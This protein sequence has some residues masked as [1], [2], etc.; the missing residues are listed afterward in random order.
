MFKNTYRSLASFVD[1]IWKGI[2]CHPNVISAILY[3]PTKI[4]STFA[5]NSCYS[6]L[7]FFL[8]FSFNKFN[9]PQ[10]KNL[11]KQNKSRILFYT[12]C[13]KIKT[14]TR[15]CCCCCCC[16]RPAKRSRWSNQK[17]SFRVLF[18]LRFIWCAK[19][20]EQ[21]SCCC[22]FLSFR[23]ETKTENKWRT[24]VVNMYC[25]TMW[26][27]ARARARVR[28]HTHN[29]THTLDRGANIHFDSERV[30]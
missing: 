30:E 17:H 11:L 6:Y 2:K 28:S 16:F 25:N 29:R 21:I 8:F 1:C 14:S 20:K 12:C 13:H 24:F 4:A 22:C 3:N 26:A 23:L 27:W 7:C 9:F 10:S 19:K 5:V 15:F 18:S